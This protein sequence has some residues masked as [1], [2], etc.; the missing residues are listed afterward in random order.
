MKSQLEVCD[1]KDNVVIVCPINFVRW[2]YGRQYYSRAD[3]DVERQ[4]IPTDAERGASYHRDR[5]C[6]GGSNQFEINP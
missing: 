3:H 4:R 2:V 1:L 6:T 5:G